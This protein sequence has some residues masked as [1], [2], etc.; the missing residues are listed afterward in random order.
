MTRRKLF[1]IELEKYKHKRKEN[2]F[3]FFFLR[4]C[5][6]WKSNYPQHPVV[7][8]HHL[9]TPAQCQP[10]TQQ[11]SPSFQTQQIENNIWI[12]TEDSRNVHCAMGLYSKGTAETCKN[13]TSRTHFIVARVDDDYWEWELKEM[14]CLR[15]RFFYHIYKHFE[16]SNCTCTR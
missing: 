2:Y 9:H 5:D 16:I 12:R 1:F 8:L 4:Y 11:W 6:Y 10:T 3:F 13:G 14:K 15:H 7:I